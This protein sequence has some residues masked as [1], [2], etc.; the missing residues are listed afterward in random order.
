MF[1]RLLILLAS[2]SVLANLTSAA[3][4]RADVAAVVSANAA[5]IPIDHARAEKAYQAFMKG[6]AQRNQNDKKFAEKAIAAA[7]ANARKHVA[8]LHQAGKLDEMKSKASVLSSTGPQVHGGAFVTRNRPNGDCSGKVSRITA[9]K[10]NGQCESDGFGGSFNTWCT[11]EDNQGN[12]QMHSSYFN[13][14]GCM[15]GW[16]YDSVVR[17]EPKCQYN[18]YGQPSDGPSMVAAQCTEMNMNIA[19]MNG[20]ITNAFFAADDVTC[21]G[22]PQSLSV[23]RYGACRFVSAEDESG[24]FYMTLD[25]CSPENG[26]AQL[27]IYTDPACQRPVSRG[28][29]NMGGMNGAPYGA[30]TPTQG[31][32]GGNGGNG[33]V[34][35]FAEGGMP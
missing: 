35:C 19:I 23:E 30:C 33:M 10:I 13:E 5:E 9:N 29:F 7:N 3:N 15:N 14:E 12:V 22:S 20:G 6:S 18:H 8:E 31:G 26:K 2:L 27:T 17:S 16:Y 32:Y 28:S 4:L 34:L 1:P 25:S 21:N 11:H 24:Y